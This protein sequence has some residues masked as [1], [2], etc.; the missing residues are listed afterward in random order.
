MINNFDLILPLLRFEF[1]THH[2]QILQRSK[3]GND[4]SSRLVAKWFVS[5]KEKLLFLETAIKSLC[6]SYNARA[7]IGINPKKDE[8]VL[9]KMLENVTERLK[10]KSFSPFNVVSSAHDSCNGNG[11]KYWI[12][13]VDDLEI[14]KGDLY[15][16][17]NKCKGG[18]TVNTIT[19]IPTK[20]GYHIIT[21]PFDTSQIKF[22]NEVS[23]HKN[24][25]TLLYC[26]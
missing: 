8:M 5:S 1:G 6:N 13:D 7:Y 19:E 20:N 22:P 17:I 23:V 9:W 2:V 3:D 15:A 11:G 16:E 26:P 18:S 25:M 4:K 24:N 21:H 10:T 12:I 14:N